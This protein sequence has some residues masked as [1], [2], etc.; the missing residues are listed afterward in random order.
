MSTRTRWP[1]VQLPC[2]TP[3]RNICLWVAELAPR[4]SPSWPKN[5][6]NPSLLPNPEPALVLCQ[7]RDLCLHCE[8]TRCPVT[9]DKSHFLHC[10]RS[11]GHSFY[12]WV[13]FFFTLSLLR[14]P[15]PD[16]A[17][18]QAIPANRLRH[19]RAPAGP[20]QTSLFNPHLQ[21]TTTT[22]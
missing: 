8:L 10:S 13:F 20:D 4:V 1:E 21:S 16:N 6:L 2:S 19:Q 7:I 15:A 3:T 5:C 11:L 9:L 12:V 17:Q 14:I 18:A 22:G